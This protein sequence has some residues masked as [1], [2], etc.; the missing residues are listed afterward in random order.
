[1][2]AHGTPHPGVVHRCMIGRG[3]ARVRPVREI[4]DLSA[5]WQ[6]KCA[7]PPR[8]DVYAD[9]GAGSS[10]RNVLLGTTSRPLL[11]PTMVYDSSPPKFS[12]HE[13]K[14]NQGGV[15]SADVDRGPALRG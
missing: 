6:T 11:A 5:P 13:P 1:M 7:R 2:C 4:Q 9:T 12:T 10:Q 8:L 3:A 15:L 14:A